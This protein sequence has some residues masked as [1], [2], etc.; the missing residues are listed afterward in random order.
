MV[1]RQPDHLAHYDSECGVV[2]G[3]RWQCFN[4][5]RLLQLYPVRHQN[6]DALHVLQDGCSSQVI[7][8]Q[9]SPLL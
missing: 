5:K 6:E 2:G 1:W 7:S 4:L 3:S 8:L 9:L